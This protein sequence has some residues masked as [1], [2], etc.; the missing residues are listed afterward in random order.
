MQNLFT[1]RFESSFFEPLWNR[2]Q[3]DHIQIT[4]S[5]DIGIGNRAQFWEETGSLKDV[6]QNHLM[7]ILAIIAMEPPTADTI[8]AEKIKV[9]NAIR[10]FPAHE[11]DDY[12]L[13]GQYGPGWVNG[14]NVPGYKQ[15]NG[16]AWNRWQKHSLQQNS[17]LTMSVGAAFLSI[18]EQGSAFPSRPLKLP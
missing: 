14:M 10:P 15:E 8:H 4:L 17:S 13:R 18:S 2:T 9:L 6:F 1:L 3:I 11:I 7:Q 5:E 16:V 12:V